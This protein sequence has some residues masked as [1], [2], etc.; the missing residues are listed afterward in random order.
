MTGTTK[1]SFLYSLKYL[2][3]TV[4]VTAVV[5]M[6][7]GCSFFRGLFADASIE[8]TTGIVNLE[9]G[10]SYNLLKIIDT[11][12][13]SFDLF[14]SNSAVAKVDNGTCIV[15]GVSV[16]TAYVTAETDTDSDKVKIVVTE[17]Q[18]DTLTVEASGE[19]I[20]TLGQTS[21]VHFT[22]IATG[23]ATKG[24]TVSW[25]V[26]GKVDKSLK[27]G[28]EFVFTPTEVGEYLIHAE[29]GGI[30][31]E[32]VT[33][34]VF[35]PVVI[36]VEYKG[37]LEQSEPFDKIVFSAKAGESENEYNYYQLYD[38]GALVYA[39]TDIEYV[40]D[41]TAGR[42]TLAWFANGKSVFNEE[43][44]FV[45]SVLPVDISV[46]YDNC[47]PHAYLM[48]D[49]QGKACVE[50]TDNGGYVKEYSQDE[51][52][53]APMFSENGFDFGQIMTVCADGNTRRTYKFRVK[54]LGDG[55]VFTESAYS[56]YITFTQLSSAAKK[57]ITTMLPCGDLYV[58]SK[59]E[60]VAIAEHYV[61][62][63]PKKSN[64]SVSFDCY[65]AFD[66]DGSA[67]DLWNEAF[68]IAATSG[69]YSGMN[70]TDL[71]SNV[72]RTQFSVSTVNTPS[73][74]AKESPISGTR[75]EQL[76]AV[77]PHINLDSSKY[78]SDDYVFPI[79]R[80]EKTMNVEY[81][82]ELYLTV[83]NGARPI[84][85]VG[86]AAETLYAMAR[87][88]LR[89]ICT[90]D[91]TD[92]QKA[93]AIYDWIMWHVTYDT[94]AT[95]ASTSGETYSAY[96]L[97]GVLA[98]GVTPVGGVVYNPYAVCDGMSKTYSL[99][100]NIEGIPC[101][102]VVGQ[103]G[104][105]LATAGGHAWNKVFVQNA[106]YVVDC[107]WGDS[108]GAMTLDGWN[109]TDYE[110]GLHD[111]LFVTDNEINSTHFEP[112]RYD[113]TTVEYA[114]KTA[115]EP[116]DIY[117]EMTVGGKTVNCKIATG[118]TQ[119]SRLRQISTAIAKAYDSSIASI[120]VPGSGSEKITYQGVEIYAEDGFGLSDS[121]ISTTVSSAIKVLHPRA[122]VRVVVLDKVALVLIK[123]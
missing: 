38:N 102:R 104:K 9:V 8:F 107:T 97:E 100:C 103:A 121:T 106:W 3:I 71:G 48:F 63:R 94:P 101:V 105:S 21:A 74:E 6:T 32:P 25:Y 36:S 122:T 99:M 2:V 23:A 4:A 109:T 56:E 80:A 116:Y 5:F 70:A 12:T 64:V 69:Y 57:Y 35:Y 13:S 85:K 87:S 50:V 7:A 37:K 52:E 115:A 61:Y 66:R 44:V 39:G 120:S 84:P 91:M 93:H 42:H 73:R 58:T 60:Y 1:K 67:L 89:K 55:D 96:Y 123:G 26:N 92:V 113:K 33:L 16:G 98:D 19:L 79:D 118:E 65:I 27:S 49:V 111:Y 117:S 110:L 15:T 45:G 59:E 90:D 112:Y 76:H 83:Q 54:S 22:A 119:T 31:A 11:E 82:D 51:G 78:R 114:P 24:K 43:C 41:P 53:Q 95:G 62:F 28:E 46:T 18:P 29:C 17:K 10:E 68:P 14:S 34:R 88:I 72:M 40:Y 75:A 20:Q 30:E 86:S 77:L 108:S 81:S 47:Y